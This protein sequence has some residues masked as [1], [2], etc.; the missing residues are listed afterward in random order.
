M[1][2]IMQKKQVHQP[3]K[4]C[5]NILYIG[6]WNFN[7]AMVGPLL[8]THRIVTLAI[9]ADTVLFFF[10]CTFSSLPS[11]RRTW[12]LTM[13]VDCGKSTWDFFSRMNFAL[14]AKSSRFFK[15]FFKLS[16]LLL[17]LYPSDFRLWIH[18]VFVSGIFN[19]DL[20]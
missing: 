11:I 1:S 9:L 20:Y 4:C 16:Y 6:R 10:K 13:L 2:E 8:R 17:M 12:N 14:C 15:Y 3:I 18:A 19:K 7:V 5:I